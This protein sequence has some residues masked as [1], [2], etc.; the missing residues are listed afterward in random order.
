MAALECSAKISWPDAIG[1]T[2]YIF[3]RTGYRLIGTEQIRRE[4]SMAQFIKTT[5]FGGVVFLVPLVIL[6]VLLGKA[7]AFSRKIATPLANVIPFG[8]VGDIIVV[9][10]AG[11]ALIILLCFLGGLAAKSV[12]V[13]RWVESLEENFLSKIPVY[14]V[15]KGTVSSTLQPEVMEGM[16]PVLAHLDD[17]SQIGFEIERVNGGKV[18]VFLPGAPEAMSGSVCYFTED[19]VTNLDTSIVT[20]VRVLKGFGKGSDGDLKAL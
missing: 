18:A 6:V 4:K 8:P 11:L 2:G 20:T 9:N 13:A 14:S 1:A 3:G 12:A 16:K 10:I 15:I 17:C 5:V 19:R 7:L